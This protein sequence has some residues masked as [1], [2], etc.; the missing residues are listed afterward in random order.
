[1][2][3]CRTEGRYEKHDTD[4]SRVERVRRNAKG[5]LNERSHRGRT[6]GGVRRRQSG[7]GSP[8]GQNINTPCRVRT[9]ALLRE[10]VRIVAGRRHSFERERSSVDQEKRAVRQAILTSECHRQ[11]FELGG[12]HSFQATDPSTSYEPN[13]PMTGAGRLAVGVAKSSQS[14]SLALPESVCSGSMAAISNVRGSGEHHAAVV[15]GAK[16][17]QITNKLRRLPRCA[18]GE[19]A[20]G[21]S[22]AH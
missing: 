20:R 9:A 13:P 1:M 4:T 10:N 15:E 16:H 21:K 5:V 6:K 19:R 7:L 3:V 12:S 2:S 11:I 17:R 14:C 18:T 8:V 22:P